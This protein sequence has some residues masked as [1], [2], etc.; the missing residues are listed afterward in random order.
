MC[1]YK[2]GVKW[3]TQYCKGN[4]MYKIFVQKSHE[5]K[6]CGRLKQG[7]VGDIETDPREIGDGKR[8]AQIKILW[9]CSQ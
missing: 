8:N 7:C 5:K 4:N 3:G 1:L 9:W 2:L 6:N